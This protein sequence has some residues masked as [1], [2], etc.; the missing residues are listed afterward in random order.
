[1][2]ALVATGG[3]GPS[4][5]EIRSRAAWADVVIAADSGLDAIL[6]AG[7]TPDIAVG[8]FDSTQCSEQL[9]SMG[10]ERVFRYSPDKD[11]TDTEIAVRHAREMGAREIG[12]VGGGGGEM[13]HFIGILSLF[14]RIVPPEWWVTDTEVFTCIRASVTVAGRPGEKVAFF[15]AGIEPCTMTSNGLRWELDGLVWNRGDI[16]VSNE[17]ADNTIE[18]TMQTGRLLMVRGLEG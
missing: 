16:G 1:V 15:P 11:E 6:A 14:D 2:K 12:I 8:D 5:R 10:S 7:V 9:S 4:D 18:V 17:F 13:A 3:R